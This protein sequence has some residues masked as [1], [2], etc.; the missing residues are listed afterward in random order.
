[1]ITIAVIEESE[2]ERARQLEVEQAKMDRENGKLEYFAAITDECQSLSLILVH[3]EHHP[4][5]ILSTAPHRGRLPLDFRP[6]IFDPQLYSCGNVISGSS[7]Q[8]HE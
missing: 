2:E 5:R 7:F 6:H 8:C 3:C 4:S 1:V